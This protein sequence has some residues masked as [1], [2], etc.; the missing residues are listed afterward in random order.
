M[1]KGVAKGPSKCCLELLR[2]TN[3]QVSRL[4]GWISAEICL[5]CIILVTIFKNSPSALRLQRP[6]T[7]DFGDLKLHEFGQIVFF[8]TDCDE[9]KLLKISYDV[10]V[11]TSPN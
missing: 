2:T 1:F 11:I 10:I 8:E 6:L 7:F 5:K 3:E 4:L 9:I